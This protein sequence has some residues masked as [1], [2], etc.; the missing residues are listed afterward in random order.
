MVFSMGG[1]HVGTDPVDTSR[2]HI[3]VSIDTGE[4]VSK[5]GVSTYITYNNNN[6]NKNNKN[7]KNNN[8]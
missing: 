6:N 5:S 2:L 7:N 4:Y 3:V 1:S 8:K